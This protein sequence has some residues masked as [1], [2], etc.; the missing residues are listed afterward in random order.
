MKKL[1]F[2]IIFSLFIISN[3][4]AKKVKFAVDMTGTDT[5]AGGMHI[6]GDF[7]TLAGYAGGDWAPNTTPLTQEGSSDIYSI[8]VD[9]PAFAKYEYV[10]TRSD[11]S[12]DAEFVPVESRVGYNFNSN[13]WIYV[14]S[15]ADDTTFV[16]AILFSGNAPAGLTLVRFLVDM[17]NESSVSADGVHVA[18]DFQGWDPA[19]TILY[20]FGSNIYEIISYV[21]TGTYEYKFYNG[22]TTGS[23]ETVPNGCS[24]NNNRLISVSADIVLATVCFSSCSDCSVGIAEINQRNSLKAYPNPFS[25]YSIIDLN[26]NIGQYSASL[27]DFTG[28]VV[29]TYADLND[30]SLR[31]EKDNLASGVY[32]ISFVSK[33]EKNTAQAKLVVE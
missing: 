30:S 6:M 22:N 5:L 26:Y 24:T 16:G 12:Y 15:L 9:I 4:S 21:N 2:S 32:F 27:T 7:Q 18:G 13:R 31:I 19:K 17:Q 33:D 8:V 25:D 29:R 3:V 28:R 10:I 23:S 11:Q 20:S 1:L 14:D